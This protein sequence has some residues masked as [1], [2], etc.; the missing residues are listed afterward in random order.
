[1]KTKFKIPSLLAALFLAVMVDSA[2]GQGTVIIQH[3]GYA[4]PTNEGFTI[5]GGGPIGIPVTNDFGMNA[6]SVATTRY[7]YF[8]TPQEESQ[9]T[10]DNWTLSATFRMINN[11]G[12]AYIACDGFG[13]DITKRL[14]AKGE[15][16]LAV[17]VTSPWKVP[18]RSHNEFMKGEFEISWDALPGPGQVV[19][20]RACIAVF[21]SR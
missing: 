12:V 19:F 3:S 1:M 10:T 18:G 16:Y 8:L 21:A 4:N 13:F 15:N 7:G 11:T 17:R 5:L 20:P 14:R 6:W 2:H 9:I